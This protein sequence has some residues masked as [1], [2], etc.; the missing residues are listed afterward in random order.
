MKSDCQ[1]LKEKQTLYKHF[2]YYC[3]CTDDIGRNN[4]DNVTDN[5]KRGKQF[6][7]V[8]NSKKPKISKFNANN[9]KRCGVVFLKAAQ[10]QFKNNFFAL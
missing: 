4:A 7:S 10:K 3:T 9:A 8:D 1:D 2:K 5:A 6:L